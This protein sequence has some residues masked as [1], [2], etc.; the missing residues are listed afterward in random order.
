MVV[1]S[2]DNQTYNP[3]WSGNPYLKIVPVIY[4]GN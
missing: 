2:P 3:D 4:Y 1:Y